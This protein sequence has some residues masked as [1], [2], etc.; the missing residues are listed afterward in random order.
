MIG[1]ISLIMFVMW[2]IFIYAIQMEND[3]FV[4]IASCGLLLVSIWIMVN[5]LEGLD[6]FVTKGFAVI[7]I[8]IGLIGIFTPIFNLERWGAD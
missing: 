1:V 6:N 3:I 4:F 7:Q 5:G 2:V 8:G